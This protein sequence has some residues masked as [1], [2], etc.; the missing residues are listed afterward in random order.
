MSTILQQAISALN[1]QPGQVYR[2]KINGQEFEVRLLE[3]NTPPESAGDISQFADLEMMVPWFHIPESPP[4]GI[5][6]ATLG[7][8]PPPDP[9]LILEV[10]EEFE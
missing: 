8:L 1:L 4:W 6:K 3:T 5:V 7:P 2:T 10:D 9:P